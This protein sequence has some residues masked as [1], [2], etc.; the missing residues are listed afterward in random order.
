[1][2]DEVRRTKTQGCLVCLLL[3]MGQSCSVANK[4]DAVCPLGG[5]PDVAVQLKT[6]RDQYRVPAIAGAIVTRQGLVKLAVAGVRKKGTT[7]PV[8]LEDTWHLGSITKAMTATCM[9]HCVEKGLLGWD[10]TV[11]DVFPALSDPLDP[12]LSRVTVLQLLSHRAGLP[13]DLELARYRGECAPQERLRAVQQELVQAP[14]TQPGSQ[15]VYSNLGYIVAGAMIEK[16]T[17]ESWEK[18]VS[19]HVFGPLGM[20]H[21]GFGGVGTPGTIDQPW[22]HT[23]KGDPVKKNGPSVDNPPVMGPAGRVH[24]TLQDWAC[25]VADQLR[26]ACG[27]PAILKASSYSTLH[28]PPFGG[29]YALGWTVTDRDW[30]GGVALNHTGSN[31]MNYANVWMAPKRNFAVLVCINQG[32][33]RAFKASD[34]AASA[35]ISYYRTLAEPNE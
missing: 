17:G 32:G 9:A 28:T 15:Y 5:A 30:A 10:T 19:D 23:A 27:D 20:A 3:I 6:I 34:A 8:T 18:N 31:T 12:A 21:A 29:D 13:K 26:G 7:I 33:D 16:V 24:C 25:F 1:M 22:G 14:E 11:A 2:L 4:G 35:L